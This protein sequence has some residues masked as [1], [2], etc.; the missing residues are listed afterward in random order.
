MRQL[1]IVLLLFGSA[2]TFGQN[3]QDKELIGLL[4]KTIRD[5]YQEA[6]P[7]CAV[8]VAKKGQVLLEKGYGL[9]NLELT[10]PMK[11]EMVFRIGSITKQFTAVAILQ[12]VDKGVLS[13]ND[14]IQK[15]VKDF[16]YKGK[17]ITI[18]NLLTHTSGIKGYEQL[19][20]RIPNAIRVDFAA[21]TVIDSLGKLP[22]DFLPG[23]KYHYSNSNYFLLG[24]I[25]EQ[26]TGKSFQQFL[27]ENI[28]EPAGLTSTFYD[29]FTQIIPNRAS[30]YTKSD[31]KYWNADYISM[32]LVYSAGAL[33]SSVADLYKWHQAL[34]KGKLVKKE[35]LSKAMTPYKLADGKETEYGYGWFI[36]TDIGFRSIGHGGGIDGFRAMEIYYPEKDIFIALLCNSEQ[37][38]AMEQLYQSIADLTLDIKSD[39]KEVKLSDKTLDSF[40]GTYKNDKHNVS[41]KIY[42]ANGRIYGDL[43]NGTGSNMVF[44]PVTETKFLLPDIR[45]IKTTAE[46]I[47]ENNKVIKV[48]MTQESPFEFIKVD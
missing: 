9:A 29:S 18:E 26:V 33:V 44:L 37:Q 20:A 40:V 34:Y 15:F 25:I 36:R 4:D 22:L 42:K 28:L 8:L 19:D 48:I 1:F 12:L 13:V 14:S 41:I 27:K 24:Y 39:F 2:A 16:P 10:V 38:A 47:K 30:G 35:T 45:R 23:S 43:S 6:A 7:G 11:S 21:K 5:K 32:S 17:T 3:K 46:F 31:G